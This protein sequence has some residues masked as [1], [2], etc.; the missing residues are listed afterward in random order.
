MVKYQSIGDLICIQ[1][2]FPIDLV[3]PHGGNSPI[4]LICFRYGA[5]CYWIMWDFGGRL[6]W[7]S[8]FSVVGIFSFGFGFHVSTRG[9]W[10]FNKIRSWELCT[11]VWR[12]EKEKGVRAGPCSKNI[13]P[14]MTYL[15]INNNV[16]QQQNTSAVLDTSLFLATRRRKQS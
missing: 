2:A 4:L 14:K 3:F 5:L 16:Q 6:S 9:L 11:V 1:D 12:K 7:P 15:K 8:Q 13:H 10:R